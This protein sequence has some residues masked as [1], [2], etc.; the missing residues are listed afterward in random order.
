MQQ[1][2]SQDLGQ[3]QK[4]YELGVHPFITYAKLTFF[5]PPDMHTY[6][7]LICVSRVRNV[8]F[9]ENFGYVL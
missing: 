4:F 8:N 9:S 6:A 2:K 3:K 5:Y 1:L 7:P